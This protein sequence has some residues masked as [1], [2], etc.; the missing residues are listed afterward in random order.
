[1][2]VASVSNDGAS[3]EIARARGRLD[4]ALFERRGPRWRGARDPREHGGVR[5]IAGSCGGGARRARDRADREPPGG[6]NGKPSDGG[7]CSLRLVAGRIEKSS[8][9]CYLDELVSKQ[10]GLLHYPCA[11]DGPAEAEFGEQRYTGRVV[12]GEV[13]LELSTELDWEDGCRWGTE[14][15]ITGA[16][17]KNGEPVARSFSWRY[18]DRVITGTDCSGVCTARTNIQVTSLRKSGSAVPAPH[19]DEDED[20]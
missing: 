4:R 17:P 16:L 20:D 8:P 6:G 19:E 3:I 10:A 13:E 14:A 11:G 18:R 1:M 12:G 9:G 2:A 7:R 5:R 15:V